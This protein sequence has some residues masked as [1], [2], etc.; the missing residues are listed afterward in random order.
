M[1]NNIWIIQGQRIV[2]ID[3]VVIF[4]LEEFRRAVV[5]STTRHGQFQRYTL[6]WIY[7]SLQ[8]CKVVLKFLI[9]N[10]LIGKRQTLFAQPV[11][12]MQNYYF[13]NLQLSRL[14][15]KMTPIPMLHRLR[16]RMTAILMLQEDLVATNLLALIVLILN[17]A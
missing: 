14:R 8:K 7:K 2:L 17:V 9:S 10:G 12:I 11:L 13:R 5:A 15:A 1:S 6:W 4:Q 16:A 3:L